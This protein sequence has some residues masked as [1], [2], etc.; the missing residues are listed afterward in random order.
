MKEKLIS[1]YNPVT[2]SPY[3]MLYVKEVEENLYSTMHLFC[4]TYEKT[5]ILDV[6]NDFEGFVITHSLLIKG[7]LKMAEKHFRNDVK[8]LTHN[9][10]RKS[11]NITYDLDL[12]LN[13]LKK[14]D[15][16]FIRVKVL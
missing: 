10:Y 3:F 6:L 1:F 13:D 15:K 16:D 11:E 12:L 2:Y 7:C 5:V 14:K 8:H 9:F 4:N